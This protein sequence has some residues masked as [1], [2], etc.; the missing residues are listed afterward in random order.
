MYRLKCRH[1]CALSLD[2]VTPY[3][4]RHIVKNK[5]RKVYKA[6]RAL[7]GFPVGAKGRLDK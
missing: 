2:F 3:E 4:T 5:A 1:L 6:L 7:F